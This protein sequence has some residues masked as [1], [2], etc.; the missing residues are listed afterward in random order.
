VGSS[1]RKS[2]LPLLSLAAAVTLLV[3]APLALAA[4]TIEEY[5]EAVEPICKRNSETSTTILKGVKTQVQQDK[6]VPAGKRFIRASTA[7]GKAVTQI[8]AE[9]Q[10]SEDEVKLDK[11]IGYLK[12]QKTYLQKIGQA[13]KAKNKVKAQQN[14]VKLNKA[15]KRANDTVISFGFN[16]CRIDS[17][18]YL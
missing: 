11:W 1:T 8:A 6:L 15:N 10:P 12:E 5:K 7:L 14:A 2:S 3:T 13:L 18:K 17:S 16:H 9:P 4:V